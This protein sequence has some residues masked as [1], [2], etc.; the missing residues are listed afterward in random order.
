LLD[1]SHYHG[2]NADQRKDQGQLERVAAAA[3]EGG[4]LLSSRQSLV[5]MR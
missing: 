3:N 2:G 1:S 5:C 4:H